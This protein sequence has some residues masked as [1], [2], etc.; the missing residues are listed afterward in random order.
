M[1][2]G[3][4]DLP[5]L[6]RLH[7]QLESLRATE[8]AVAIEEQIEEICLNTLAELRRQELTDG[9]DSFLRAHCE[10]MMHRI[11]DP[12]LRQMHWMEG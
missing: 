4:Q 8:T 3:L 12:Q 2:R 6:P 11:R 5:K 10:A 9:S 1:F 7:A